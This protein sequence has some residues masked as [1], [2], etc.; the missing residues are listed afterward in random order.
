MKL[1]IKLFILYC[2]FITLL[3]YFLFTNPKKEKPFPV[4][5]TALSNTS[6]FS[7]EKAKEELDLLVQTLIKNKIPI[8]EEY[9]ILDDSAY[10]RLNPMIWNSLT[11]GEQ[12]QVCDILAVNKVWKDS[13]LLNG[14]LFVFETRIGRIGPNWSGGFEFKPELSSLK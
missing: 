1:I 8:I 2:A 13:G 11:S 4:E 5:Q 9:T 12:R 3:I 10:I 7:I 14:R 6:E